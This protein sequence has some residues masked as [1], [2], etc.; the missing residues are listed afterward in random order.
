MAYWDT[1]CLAKLYVPEPDSDVFQDF[2]AR[3]DV[4]RTSTLS[5]LE[6]FVLV[7]R[8][9]AEGNLRP[10]GA[11]K[12]VAQY[13][14]DIASNQILVVPP[15]AKVLVPFE[16]IVRQCAFRKPSLLVRT[17][18]ALHL[19]TAQATGETVIVTTDKRMREAALVLGF[20]R[21]PGGDS[22]RQEETS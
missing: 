5:R 11:R 15:D 21:M 12:A 14:E 2:A 19:A 18:D 7:H 22:A 1:S 16:A 20:K 9:E 17:L 8:K 10:G 4:I 6:F 13:D 3:G